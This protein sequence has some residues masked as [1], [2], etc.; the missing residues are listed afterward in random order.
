[1]SDRAA[2][3]PEIFAVTPPVSAKSSNKFFC[4]G[5]QWRVQDF[6]ERGAPTPKII[7]FCKYFAKNCMKMKEFGPPGAHV[8]GTP[9]RS[10]NGYPGVS[11][12]VTLTSHQKECIPVGAS[13]A[14][15][16][17]HLPSVLSA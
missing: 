15:S 3:M 2:L 17:D 8:P 9:L 11:I 5:Y 7:I 13:V 12:K 1:M 6:P 16:R 14:I 10:T 4:I